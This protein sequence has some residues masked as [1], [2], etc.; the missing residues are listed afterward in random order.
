MGRVRFALMAVAAVV[1]TLGLAAPAGAQ[2]AEVR[3]YITS[4]GDSTVTFNSTAGWIEPGLTGIIVDPARQDALMGR[5]RV[6]SVR[7][8]VA[9]ALITGETGEMQ[10]G[11]VAIMQTPHRRFFHQG[12]FWL[13]ALLGAAIGAVIG[14]SM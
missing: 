2:H 13:G 4:V 8:G 7:G 1:M 11:F 6:M 12:T 14:A 3:F 10:S 5:F 9:T